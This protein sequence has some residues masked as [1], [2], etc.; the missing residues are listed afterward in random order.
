MG[1]GGAQALP[2]PGKWAAAG[3]T[4]VCPHKD[5]CQALAISRGGHMAG[6]LSKLSERVNKYSAFNFNILPRVRPMT[7]PAEEKAL[8][9]LLFP[10][11]YHPRKKVSLLDTRNNRALLASSS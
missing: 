11:S 2:D 5:R 8:P 4:S 9:S 7:S 10:K 1:K 6:A 3:V